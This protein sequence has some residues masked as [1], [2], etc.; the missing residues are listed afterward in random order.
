M[1]KEILNFAHRIEATLW[2]DAPKGGNYLKECLVFFGVEG[3]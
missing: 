1:E 3:F 2:R